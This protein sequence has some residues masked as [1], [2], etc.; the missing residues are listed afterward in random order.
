MT[1][2]R[3]GTAGF[4]LFLLVAIVPIAASLVYSFLY[5]VGLTGLLSEGATTRHW[6]AVLAGS[7]FRAAG[8]LSLAVAASVSLVAT[9][10]GLALALAFGER[11]RRGALSYAFFLPLALPPV[12][13]AFAGYQLLSPAGLLSRMVRALRLSAGI[14]TFPP[15]TNDFLHAGVILTHVFIALP[16]LTVV[17]VQLHESER[18]P[19]YL[20]LSRSLGASHWQS[21]RLVAVPMLLRRAAPNVLL[22]FIVVFG[23]YEIPLLLGR[24]SPLMI[25]VLAVRKYQRFD[26]TQKPQAFVIAIL[27]AIF[28]LALL[29]YALTRRDREART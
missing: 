27:Y 10:G 25:S 21:I 24:Q 16:F 20:A 9:A 19:E 6:A 2:D 5:T 22:L 3:L 17:F 11:I 23:S 26:V 8:L 1:R 7:D 29:T 12:V 15:L 28:V 18:I 14:E 4:L 13:A